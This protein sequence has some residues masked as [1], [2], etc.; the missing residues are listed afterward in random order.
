M[1]NKQPCHGLTSARGQRRGIA[2]L[3][4]AVCLP[5]MFLLLSGLWEVGRITEVQ[6]VM[7]NSTREAA[8]DC[9]LGQN[10]LLTVANNLLAYLQAA[11]P[12]AFAQGHSTSMVAPSSVGL[13]LPANTT[14]YTCWDNTAN[15]ELFTFTF[16][17]K[18]KPT[19]TDPTG[20]SQ[21]DRYELTVQV[22]YATI[23]WTPLARVTGMS[24]LYVTMDWVS[25]VDSP[26][27]IPASLPAQ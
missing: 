12:R 2:A 23:G 7:W 1:L 9:S 16:T 4:L 25:M 6:N 13:T 8:R 24:R 19:V 5:L 17:D 14:G 3:E 15:R 21:L 11:E 27:A 26:F 10:N 20:A 18:T 22:P